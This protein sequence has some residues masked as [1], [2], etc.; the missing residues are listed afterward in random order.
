MVRFGT[1]EQETHQKW[2][3]LS[4]VTSINSA[5]NCHDYVQSQFKCQVRY[6]Y[7]TEFIVELSGVVKADP[8]DS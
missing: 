5:N 6:I 3:L 8:H 4:S 7:N 2:K 1:Q